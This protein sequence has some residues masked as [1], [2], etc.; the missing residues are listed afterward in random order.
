MP[1]TAAA[2]VEAFG[3]RGGVFVGGDKRARYRTWLAI[4]RRARTTSWW[5]RGRRCSRRSPTSGYRASRGRATRRT[6]R[7]GRRTTTSGTSRWRGRGSTGAVCVLVRAV[8]V[9]GGERARGRPR[10]RPSTRRW[11]PVEV[12]R[13]GPE[14][15]APRLV[16]ALRE[17]RRAFLFS[18][19]PGLRDGAG[20]PSV[21]R[22]GGVRRVRRDAPL[23]GG[24][25]P[26]RRVRGARAVRELRGDGLRPPARR[27]RTGRGVG[28]ARGG[29]SRSR[30]VATRG[31]ARLPK[32]KRDPRGRAGGRAGPRPPAAS[33]SSRSSTRTW[34]SGGR[35]WPPRERALATWMEAVGWARPSGRA[36]VQADRPSDPADPGARARQ[37]RS[38]PRATRHAR[39]A[40]AGF[41]VGFAG[42]PDRRL[43]RARG[44]ARGRSSP[45][46]LLVSSVGGQTVCLLALEPGRVRRSVGRSA[47]SRSR[48][49]VTRVEAEPH[50]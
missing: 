31:R 2:I 46:T 39:R 28:A 18:P 40:A 47:S 27:R 10:S 38:V 50:L 1:A 42:V 8:S 3:E 26:V 33:T 49:I 30:R 37:P 32:A 14:G 7:S 17:T 41:P 35:G 29:A 23:G 21:R 24:R 44:R 6:A 13:A 25:G 19:L 11:P 5:G 16:R 48:D 12:V 36:I 22:P 20:V 43:R 15:R 9:V 45:I 34:R 4:A